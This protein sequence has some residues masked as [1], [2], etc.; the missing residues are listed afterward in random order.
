MKKR[1]PHEMTGEIIEAYDHIHRAWGL[2][3]TGQASLSAD[4]PPPPWA[5]VELINALDE[6]LGKSGLILAEFI[7]GEMIK[8]GAHDAKN[9]D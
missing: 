3:R 6:I 1:K 9:P 4:N 2:I 5:I 7:D 8:T